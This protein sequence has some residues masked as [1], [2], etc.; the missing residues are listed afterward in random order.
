MKR[1]HYILIAVLLLGIA[2]LGYYMFTTNGTPTLITEK[3]TSLSEEER[4]S[5]EKKISDYDTQIANTQDAKQLFSLNIQKGYQQQLLGKLLEAKNSFN[6]AL[7]NDIGEGVD[8]AYVALFSVEQEMGDYKA[9]TKSINKAIELEPRYPDYW[10]RLA[11]FQKEI[12]KLSKAKVYQT[13]DKALQSTKDDIDVVTFYASTAEQF[14][15][16][17]KAVEMW[18]KA[19]EINPN[20]SFKYEIEL[21]RIRG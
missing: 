7:E 20:N 3:A 19:I 13:L 15:D 12:L 10:R 4:Q 18:Q 6:A 21:R 9:A 8:A 14:G 1:K 17:E 11:I 5:V 2:A 16:I